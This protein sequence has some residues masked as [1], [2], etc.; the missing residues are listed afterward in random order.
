MK[1][2]LII[3]GVFAIGYGLYKW[4]EKK[5][6][7]DCGC[8]DKIKAPTKKDLDNPSVETYNVKETASNMMRPYLTAGGHPINNIIE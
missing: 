7:P 2:V 4:Y 1:N 6:K 8:G 5:V 3:A